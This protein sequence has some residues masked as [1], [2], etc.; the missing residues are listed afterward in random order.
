MQHDKRITHLYME[1]SMEKS[2]MINNILEWIESHLEQPLNVEIIAERAGY[3]KRAFHDI[4]KSITGHNIATY[5]RRRR[6]SKSATM[7]LLG[8]KPIAKI[9]QLFQFESQAY[10]TRAFKQYF[11]QTP[12]AFRKGAINFALHQKPHHVAFDGSYIFD[13]EKIE[14][15]DVLGVSYT[16][17]LKISDVASYSILARDCHA[18]VRREMNWAAASNHGLTSVKTVISFNPDEKKTDCLTI[19]Y[20]ISGSR[21]LGNNSIMTIRAGKYAKITYIGS[22][23]GYISFSSKIYGYILP[24]HNVVRRDGVDFE[25]FSMEKKC[26]D[27][28]H[29]EYHVPID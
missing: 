9:A 25:V 22:W 17:R 2:A 24:N 3:S 15:Q 19:K 20:H 5:I 12:A 23:D 10:Y 18:K 13:I 14:R 29:C 11:N 1:G 16:M 7:L 4:F 26:N 28:I 8:N 6:L 21:H 27:V